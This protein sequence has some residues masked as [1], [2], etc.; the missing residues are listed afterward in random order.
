LEISDYLTLG[1]GREGRLEGPSLKRHKIKKPG[2]GG[3]ERELRSGNNESG[4]IHGNELEPAIK[5][6]N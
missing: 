4:L 3:K 6:R 2:G 5:G 1:E